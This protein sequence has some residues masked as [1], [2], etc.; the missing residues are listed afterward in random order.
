M[1]HRPLDIYLGKYAAAHIAE[2]GWRG[3]DIATL[4]GASGGPKWLILG[5]LDRL[6]F[7]DYLLRDREAPISAIGSSVGSWRHGCL[8]QIDPVAAIDRFEEI[9]VGWDYSAKPDTEEISA[10]SASMLEHIFGAEGARA[11]VGSDV[12][13][14]YIVTARGR[15]LNSSQRSPA[16]VTGMATAAVANAISRP[17]LA[18]Q[19][20]RVVFARPDAPRLPLTDFRTLQVG[21]DEATVPRALHASGSI[22]FLLEGERDLPGAPPG[23]Y[24]DGGIIDYHFDPQALA[25][26]GLILYPHFRSDLTPGWFDKFLPWR[27]QQTPILDNLILL[28]PSQAFLASLPRGKIPDRG[29]FRRLAPSDRIA[30]W[31]VCVDRSKELAEDFHRQLQESD[32]LAGTKRL[33][34]V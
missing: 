7:G 14:T 9:Y 33:P 17:L 6:L 25:D 27:R 15:G 11:I 5:H 20:Q 10:A 32:P 1:K 21:L 19:F 30:Y 26:R 24:W 8:P 31:R 13:N 4:L 2:H 22:P 12:V 23:H 3:K 28:N 16:L 29:D 18:T 34:E